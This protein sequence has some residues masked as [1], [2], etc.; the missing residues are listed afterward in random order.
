MLSVQIVATYNLSIRR[1]GDEHPHPEDLRVMVS[2][3]A[4]AASDAIHS[5]A[6]K[7]YHVDRWLEEKFGSDRPLVRELKLQAR[8]LIAEL[9][10][11]SVIRSPFSGS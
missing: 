1:D 8:K 2:R 10:Q 5:G 11:Q 9:D 3:K 4:G 7:P 6:I